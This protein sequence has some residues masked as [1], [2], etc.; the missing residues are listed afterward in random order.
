MITS[1]DL[2]K[3]VND[4]AGG[5]ADKVARMLKEVASLDDAF[6]GDV[7]AVAATLHLFAGVSLRT[8]LEVQRDALYAEIQKD[9]Q[10][11]ASRQQARQQDNLADA[12]ATDATVGQLQSQAQQFQAQI[13]AINANLPN[14]LR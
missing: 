2:L 6:G 8:K 14:L 5:D 10:D 9:Q 7:E 12:Q 3:M 1:D 11:L 4:A 13:D